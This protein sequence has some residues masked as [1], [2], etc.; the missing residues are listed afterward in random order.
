MMQKHDNV[1]ETCC[2]VSQNPQ[3]TISATLFLIY[4]ALISLC[5]NPNYEQSVEIKL[6]LEKEFMF[7]LKFTINF[8]NNAAG[9]MKRHITDQNQI[10][11]FERFPI[12]PCMSFKNLCEP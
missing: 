3:N 5:R 8:T 4:D 9:V 6:N 2:R 1:A 10:Q 11:A 7:Y 12:M